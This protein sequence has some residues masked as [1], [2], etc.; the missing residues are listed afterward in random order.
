MLVQCLYM[1]M[2]ICNRLFKNKSRIKPFSV[3]ICSLTAWHEVL[4]RRDL[5]AC[6]GC[7]RG[8]HSGWCYQFGQQEPLWQ[9]HS[10]LHHKWRHCT[11]IHAWGG[12]WPGE[13]LQPPN[14]F[15]CFGRK[16]T[17]TSLCHVY[18]ASQA[19]STSP[20]CLKTFTH[21]KKTIIFHVKYSS[22]WP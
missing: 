3:R 18:I 5:W 15:L 1:Y 12:C 13:W 2:C 7:P 22:V 10:Y 17:F 11:Q 21:I 20:F 19:R 6:V 4:H 9:R 8:R 16:E 14:V